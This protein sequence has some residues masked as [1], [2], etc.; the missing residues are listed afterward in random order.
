MS[1]GHVV[2]S[3]VEQA[4]DYPADPLYAIGAVSRYLALALALAFVLAALVPGLFND[5][6]DRSSGDRLTAPATILMS[7]TR[8][9]DECG[10]AQVSDE[11]HGCCAVSNSC[12]PCLPVAFSQDGVVAPWT[13]LAIA[14]GLSP[15]GA[16]VDPGLRPPR[17]AIRA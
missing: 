11:A 5:A 15:D 13:C 2:N 17:L 4:L 10:G 12:S 7:N 9:A 8:F 16:C 3:R 6:L 14:V 1:K